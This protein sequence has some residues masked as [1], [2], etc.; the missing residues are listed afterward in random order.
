[1]DDWMEFQK[2]YLSQSKQFQ[3]SKLFVAS[4]L[5]IVFFIV[6]FFDYFNNNF[7]YIELIVF[8]IIS[9][10]WMIFYPKI[11]YKQCLAKSKKMLGEGDNSAV[12][13]LCNVEFFDDYFFVKTHG[14]ES[15]VN[16][17]S[18]K[19][20]GE[21]GKYIFMHMTSISAFIIPKLKIGN[22]KDEVIKFIKAK[23]G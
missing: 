22:Q 9:V 5:P 21:N 15:K 6:S 2:Y 4:V 11:F 7:D 14:G 1:M 17:S 13:G 18:I 16:W 20:V 23:T 8:L 12:L 10:L 19:K 3:R